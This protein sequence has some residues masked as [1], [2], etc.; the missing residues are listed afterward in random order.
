M[1]RLSLISLLPLILISNV[2][3]QSIEECEI[4]QYDTY[5]DASLNWYQDLTTITVSE[6][7]D[8]AGVSEWFLEGR[9]HHFELSRAVVHDALHNSPES[10]S[11]SRSIE[12]WLQL[13]QSDVK[14]LSMR[15]DEI[16][17]LAKQTFNDRQSTPHEKN[18]DLRSAFAELLSHP[19]KI[20][21]ALSKYNEKMELIEQSPCK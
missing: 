3:A 20:D 4:Q 7:P 13:E 2:S 1:K 16:G 10:I 8:L 5:I 9:K 17:A 6:Y 21:T 12:S 18:Y 15:D 19:K 14:E 11:T